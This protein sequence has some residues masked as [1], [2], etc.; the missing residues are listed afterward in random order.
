MPVALLKFW[1]RSSGVATFL[2][3]LDE[4]QPRFFAACKLTSVCEL[5]APVWRP[6][7]PGSDDESYSS[8]LYCSSALALRGS[9]LST[10]WEE[11]SKLCSAQGSECATRKPGDVIHDL[12]TAHLPSPHRA[13]HA[14]PRIAMQPSFSE[15]E[16]D[17]ITE[18]AFSLQVHQ[19]IAPLKAHPIH[20]HS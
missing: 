5:R 14:A 1:W 11:V 17:G 2:H 9:A 15:R 19:R 20:E 10:P 18:L 7:W 4:C 3:F 13:H 12:K 16:S 6:D 8:S